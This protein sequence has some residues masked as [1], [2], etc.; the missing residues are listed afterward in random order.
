MAC[1][2]AAFH[3][4]PPMIW[5]QI[6]HEATVAKRL[7]RRLEP[8]LSESGLAKLALPSLGPC[9]LRQL[10]LTRQKGVSANGFKTTSPERFPGAFSP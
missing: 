1:M 8:A 6:E 2:L 3:R 4:S 9:K 7:Q 5:D 10:D